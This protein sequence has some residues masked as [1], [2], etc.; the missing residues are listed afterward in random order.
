MP[1]IGHVDRQAWSRSEHHRDDVTCRS[2]MRH[3]HLPSGVVAAAVGRV[4]LREV[5][6]I[7]GRERS[8]DRR[9]RERHEAER[10]DAS[11]NRAMGAA[12]HDGGARNKNPA[13]SLARP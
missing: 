4:G 6:Q 12:N 7:A 13:S 10:E 3:G 1:A 9:R 5:G 8:R 2:H 11:E